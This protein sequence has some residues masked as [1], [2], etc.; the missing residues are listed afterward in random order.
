M[1]SFSAYWYRMFRSRSAV[2][3]RTRASLGGLNEVVI[4]VSLR[5]TCPEFLRNQSFHLDKNSELC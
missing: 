3:S 2:V 1:T 5:P 4:A